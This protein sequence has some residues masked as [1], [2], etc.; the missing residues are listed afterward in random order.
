LNFERSF[1]TSALLALLFFSARIA[2]GAALDQIKPISKL[3]EIDLAKL[4]QGEVVGVR[5]PLGNFVRGIYCESAFFIHAPVALAGEKF[6]HWNPGK[7]PELDVSHYHEYRRPASSSVWDP[8]SL[9]SAHKEE[10]W[11]TE[12]TWQLLLTMGA[13]TELHVTRADVASFHE[14]TRQMRN[15]P[16][17]NDRD[18]VV[19]GFWRKV[20]RARSDAVANGGLAALPAYSDQ[21][22]RIDTHGEFQNLLRLAPSIASHFL[23]LTNGSPFKPGADAAVEVI[24]YW[25][26][27]RARGHANLH[28]AFLVAR[29]GTSSWQLADCTYYVSDTYFMSVS[30]YEFFPQE[31]GTLV[32]QIDFASA[33]F[34]S[35]TGGLDRVF[36]GGEM[37]KETAQIAKLF[38]AD[39]ER[40]Q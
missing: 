19:S 13:K 20:L 24:P 40:N 34:R 21:S 4:K 30:L 22:V 23:G 36:A 5:G 6:L 32:W 11:L 3:P 7:H 8:L 37:L 35:F 39:V 15:N 9:T 27:A 16:S 33:P 14:M 26:V 28:G 17:A 2:V 29:K 38:R 12:R 31:N 10:K 25:E 18:A 1:K